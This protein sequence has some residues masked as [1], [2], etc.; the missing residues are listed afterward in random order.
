MRDLLGIVEAQNVAPAKPEIT[1]P[2]LTATPG[3]RDQP[4]QG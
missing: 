2:S 4:P 3:K 1:G